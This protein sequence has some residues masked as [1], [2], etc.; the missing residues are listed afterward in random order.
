MGIFKKNPPSSGAIYDLKHFAQKSEQILWPEEIMLARG[1][2]N[3]GDD[4]TGE[5]ALMNRAF[6]GSSQKYFAVTN[7][8]AIVGFMG[9][10][11]VSSEPYES[12][13]PRL[14]SEGKKYFYSY[15]NPVLRGSSAEVSTLEIT[16]IMFTALKEVMHNGIPKN[17]PTAELQLI[18]KDWGPGPL[19]DFGR[20]KSGRDFMFIFVCSYCSNTFPAED[21][22]DSHPEKAPK[23]CHTCLRVNTGTA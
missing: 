7:W 17:I 22:A 3:E 4:P 18:K 6:G 9:S 16:Q 21:D 20:A 12:S 8:R 15:S 19:G 5:K 2:V 11:L 1:L 14:W 23:S 10:G 13:A